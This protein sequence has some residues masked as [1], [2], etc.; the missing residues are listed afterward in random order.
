MTGPRRNLHQGISKVFQPS[1][2]DPVPVR[3]GDGVQRR[4]ESNCASGFAG[5][6]DEIASTRVDGSPQQAT[7]TPT[8]T[9]RSSKPRPRNPARQR[10][11]S[12][13]PPAAEPSRSS[14]S[15]KP[16]HGVKVPALAAV[17]Q[18]HR[19]RFCTCS[20]EYDD[21]ETTSSEEDDTDSEASFSD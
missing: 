2:E 5:E 13:A 15:S 1:A 20:P 7:T 19:L 21:E 17:L 4:V 10:S 3:G 12:V 6:T 16:D 11:V 9:A 8:Q 14:C 18:Y